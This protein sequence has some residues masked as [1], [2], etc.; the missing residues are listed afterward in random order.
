MRTIL[1]LTLATVLGGCPAPDSEDNIVLCEY[2]DQLVAWADEA[3]DGTVPADVL[4]LAEGSVDTTGGYADSDAEID[5]T[6][7][8]ARRGDHAVYRLN[9]VGGCPSYLAFPVTVTFVTGDGRFDESVATDATLGE[10]SG[11]GLEVRAELPLERVDGSFEAPDGGEPYGVQLVARFTDGAVAGEVE[12]QVQ[13]GDGDD[14]PD[15]TVWASSE[16]WFVFG[17]R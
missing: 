8:L 17:A 1:T 12:V 2:D 9:T 15:G 4:A 11:E 14:G 3:P 10:L 7:S 16:T 13:G 6:A 5:V